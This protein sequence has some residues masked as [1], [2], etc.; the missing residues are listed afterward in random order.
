MTLHLNLAGTHNRSSE[1]QQEIRE[2]KRI[3]KDKV[4]SDWEYGPLPQHTSSGQTTTTG[5][6]GIQNRIAGFN[7]HTSSILDTHGAGVLGLDFDPLDWC[8]RHHSS[9][10]EDE[11]SGDSEKCVAKRIKRKLKGEEKSESAS[12]EKTRSD[13]AQAFQR[14][15]ARKR[16]RQQVLGAEVQWNDGLAHWL[17]RRDVWCGARNVAE[18]QMLKSSAHSSSGSSSQSDDSTPRTS[19]SSAADSSMTLNSG[20]AATSEHASTTALKTNPQTTTGSEE[21]LQSTSTPD[22][23]VGLDASQSQATQSEV[24][25]ADPLPDVLIPIAPSILPDHPIRQ[26]ITSN[27]YPEIYSK[28]IIQARTPSIPINLQTLT[29]ALVAGWKADDEWPPKPGLIEKSLG[30][31]KHQVAACAEGTLKHGVKAVGRA[32]RLT[33]TADSHGKEN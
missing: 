18:V 30:R 22:H 5:L 8:E 2:A 15:Q 26:R 33:H 31:K 23:G 24:T 9:D 10:S 7:F 11:D 13:D 20:I 32:L 17:Q 16:K 14:R 3:L 19:T 1:Q 25:L 28:I 4:R 21:S 12:P 29:S 6:D 27:T